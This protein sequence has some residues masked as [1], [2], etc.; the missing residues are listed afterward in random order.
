M[1]S[2]DF[3]FKVKQALNRI[4]E[5]TRNDECIHVSDLLTDMYKS[6]EVKE[7]VFTRGKVYHYAIENLLASEFE[8]AIIEQEFFVV[9]DNKPICFTPDVILDNHIIEIKSSFSSFEYAK[10][11]TSI[12]R[13]LLESYTDME[14]NGCVMI[15]GDLK[16]YDLGCTSELGKKELEKRLKNSLMRFF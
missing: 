1:A 14:I 13:Y 2:K 9:H 8:N 11:Q 5:N 15:T 16:I 4:D 6:K 7:E 3:L 12:Y 10:L